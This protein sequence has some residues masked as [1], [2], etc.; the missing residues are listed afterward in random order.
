MRGSDGLG[1]KSVRKEEPLGMNPFDLLRGSSER[2]PS[3]WTSVSSPRPVTEVRSSTASSPH[4]SE[5]LACS[6]IDERR[7]T[8]NVEPSR[9]G[10]STSNVSSGAATVSSAASGLS[11][12]DQAPSRAVSL[13]S[14]PLGASS[15]R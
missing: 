12:A 15:S 6:Q 3:R 2:K 4:S 10:G 11:M 9:R 1:E 14:R 5:T 7:S 13:A 8:V